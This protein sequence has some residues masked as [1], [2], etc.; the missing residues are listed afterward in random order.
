MDQVT[1][2]EESVQ[3]VVELLT[4]LKIMEDNSLVDHSEAGTGK[5]KND[6][7]ISNSGTRRSKG[8]KASKMS[9]LEK[10]FVPTFNHVLDDSN[11]NYRKTDTLSS[12]KHE[13][14]HSNGS[15]QGTANNIAGG[16]VGGGYNECDEEDFVGLNSAEWDEQQIHN[17]MTTL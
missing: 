15:R 13:K 10:E 16:G 4:K 17:C 9:T 1:L 8:P 5:D 14:L 2:L 11:D 12:N 6:F 3:I 7:D